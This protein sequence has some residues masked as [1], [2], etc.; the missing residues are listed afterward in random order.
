M[1]HIGV[2][3]TKGICLNI[4]H[5]FFSSTIE[6]QCSLQMKLLPLSQKNM[7]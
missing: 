3:L 4:T 7:H 2:S 6:K 1:Y 5:A